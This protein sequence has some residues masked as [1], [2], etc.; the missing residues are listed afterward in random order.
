MEVYKM[1]SYL[2]DLCK[3]YPKNAK[4]FMFEFLVSTLAD[5]RKDL[6]SVQ[7]P[8]LILHDPIRLMGKKMNE[9]IK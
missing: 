7:T 3:I 8:T 2:H 6:G 5:L 4:L 9:G 1:F